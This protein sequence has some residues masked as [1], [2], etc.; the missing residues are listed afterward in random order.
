LGGGPPTSAG[1]ALGLGELARGGGAE[2]R[3]MGRGCGGTTCGGGFATLALGGGAA[4]SCAAGVAFGAGPLA[5][6]G[7][8]AEGGGMGATAPRSRTNHTVAAAA[9]VAAIASPTRA[10]RA[11]LCFGAE[12]TSIGS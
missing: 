12:L 9:T 11:P 2:G 8:A 7:T 10:A 4:E 5:A 1:G 3:V 6:A